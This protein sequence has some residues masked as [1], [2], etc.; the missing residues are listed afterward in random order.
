MYVVDEAA[1]AQAIVMRAVLRVTVPE[2]PFTNALYGAPAARSFRP[3]RG[4]RSFRLAGSPSLR[5]A[6]H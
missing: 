5:R 4:A 1:V 6:Q 3:N 2:S